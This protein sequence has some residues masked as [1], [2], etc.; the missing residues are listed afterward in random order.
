MLYNVSAYNAEK[1]QIL[2][3]KLDKVE[4]FKNYHKWF[5]LKKFLLNEKRSNV[6][7]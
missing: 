6:L 7:N 1:I 2:W 3:M 4:W 5:L